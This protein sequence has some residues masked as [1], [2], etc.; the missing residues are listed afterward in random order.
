MI[1]V[2]LYKEARRLRGKSGIWF[3]DNAAA[4]HALV[5]GSSRQHDLNVMAGAIHALAFQLQTHIFFEW[6]ESAANWADGVSRDGLSDTWWRAHRFQ[7]VSC[8]VPAIALKL[9][10]YPTMIVGSFL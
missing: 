7:V 1:L 4:T 5:T 3:V 6:V 8:A 10:M 2:A 9:P